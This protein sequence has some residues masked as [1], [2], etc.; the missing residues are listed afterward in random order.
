MRSSI[1]A[2]VPML[3]LR[4]D[5]PADH[6]TSEPIDYLHSTGKTLYAEPGNRMVAF[7]E[8]GLWQFGKLSYL[9]ITIDKPVIVCFKNPET[10]QQVEYGP[11]EQLRLDDGF[12]RAGTHFDRMI[13]HFSDF[14]QQWTLMGQTENMPNVEIRPAAQDREDHHG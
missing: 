9:G 11:F 13:S 12:M 6:L 10:G 8:R 2:T 5:S 14:Q 7:H 3:T 4:F 1:K